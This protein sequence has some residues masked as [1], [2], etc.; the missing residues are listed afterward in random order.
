MDLLAS[1]ARE[2]QALR[3]RDRGFAPYAGHGPAVNPT[4]GNKA[5]RGIVVHAPHVAKAGRGGRK[6]ARRH[7]HSHGGKPGGA[8]GG[9]ALAKLQ[10]QVDGLAAQV[11]A[12]ASRLPPVPGTEMPVLPGA[13][14]PVANGVA[15]TPAP[16]AADVAAPTLPAPVA[17]PTPAAPLGAAADAPVTQ[18][19]LR[20]ITRTVARLQHH[21]LGLL[22]PLPV[23]KPHY[24]EDEEVQK[25]LPDRVVALE[26][27]PAVLGF[28]AL[29]RRVANLE[30][31]VSDNS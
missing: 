8:A 4:V 21:V 15:P 28:D 5:R 30:D 26:Q 27:N 18:A 12:L 10:L 7:G 9:D 1:F 20:L 29:E 13:V 24:D 3:E 31:R 14:L 19:D 6:Q 17:A 11:Q 22:N 2:A 23:E 25:G 16:D